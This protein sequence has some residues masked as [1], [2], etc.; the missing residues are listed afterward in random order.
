MLFLICREQ[1]LSG[2][3]YVRV[4]SESPEKLCADEAEA[5]AYCLTAEREP[6]P[7]E[8]MGNTTGFAIY[9]LDFPGRDAPEL[10][11]RWDEDEQDF[12]P[13]H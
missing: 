2:D 6:E 1:N 3:E 7:D 12:T 11:A 5:R 13:A 8:G 4:A 9:R 10:V